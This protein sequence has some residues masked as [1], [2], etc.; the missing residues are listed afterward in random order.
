MQPMSEVWTIRRALEWTMG[1]L[2][3]KG[4]ENPRLSAQWL[5]SEATGLSRVELYTHYD[6]PLSLSERDLLRDFVT[7]RGKGEPLQYITGEVGFR[8]IVVKVRP[9]VLI[10]RPETEVLVSEALA[11]LPTIPAK[12]CEALGVD[13][14]DGQDMEDARAL[15]TQDMRDV[16]DARGVQDTCAQHTESDGE[17]AV[18]S[19]PAAL[20]AD[21]CTGTGCI[22]C[23]IAHER[24]GVCVIATDI[25]SCAVELARQNA[26]ALG[27]D[28]H[29]E[30]VECDLADGI[31][32]ALLGAFDLIVSN[33]PYV[34]TAVLADIPREVAEFEPVL[35]LDGGAD[36]LDIFRRILQFATCALRPGGALAVELHETCL[37]EAAALAAESGFIDCRIVEDLTRRPRVLT[38]RKP[39]EA[40]D[41]NNA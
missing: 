23:S 10:P 8:H 28:T 18:E 15:R 17:Q 36:G 30:V 38:V 3:R 22:A 7:R 35:A 9:G 1:Y 31:P 32:A 6:Q 11:L 20:V 13:A 24:P 14:H 25:A 41:I 37:E 21:L 27:L 29:V 2:E 40:T 33:P 39:I 34:P 26:R 12:A 19:A 5:L 4:D 16:Q